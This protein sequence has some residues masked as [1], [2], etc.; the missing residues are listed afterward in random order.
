MADMPELA[1]ALEAHLDAGVDPAPGV[2]S[3]Y[4]QHFPNL[5][6]LDREWTTA[7]TSRI[8]SWEA[9]PELAVAAW[10]SY[11]DRLLPGQPSFDLFPGS[12]EPPP[13]RLTNPKA[14]C[15]HIVP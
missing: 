12:Y 6:S 13:P 9:H 3:V 8:F 1:A 2:R 14:P 7:M 4:G 5:A 11:L 10:R 15:H